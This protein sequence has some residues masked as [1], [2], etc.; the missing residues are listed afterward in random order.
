MKTVERVNLLEERVNGKS[1]IAG[2]RRV[3]LSLK[4]FEI[5][6]LRVKL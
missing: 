4:P 6:S 1:R 2:G 3:A 5:V